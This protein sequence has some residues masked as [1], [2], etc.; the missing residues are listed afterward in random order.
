VNLADLPHLVTSKNLNAAGLLIALAAA[1]LMAFYPPRLPQF[2][3]DG[4]A[5]FTWL[6]NPTEEGK[7]KGKRQ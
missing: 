2:T 5:I 4:A 7:R 1:V 3:K 6:G